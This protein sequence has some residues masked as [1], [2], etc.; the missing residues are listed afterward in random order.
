MA[1]KHKTRIKNSSSKK[2]TS[3]NKAIPKPDSI[4]DGKKDVH[5]VFSEAYLKYIYV[6][7]GAFFLLM[8]AFAL[9]MIAASEGRKLQESHIYI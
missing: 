6:I 5:K 7:L 4:N 2:T 9:L 1:A 3:G 8:A